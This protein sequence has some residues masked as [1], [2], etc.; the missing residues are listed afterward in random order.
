MNTFKDKE[1]VVLKGLNPI[2]NAK[3]SPA[4]E[5]HH[6]RTHRDLSALLRLPMDR[7]PRL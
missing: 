6:V 5:I 7:K 1:D 2:L 4:F 3:T